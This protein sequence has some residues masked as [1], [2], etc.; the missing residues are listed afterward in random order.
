[1]RKE[2]SE[3]S[4]IGLTPL[5]TVLFVAEVR[6]TRVRFE[7][8]TGKDLPFDGSHILRD[9]QRA[10]FP[11]LKKPFSEGTRAGD[12]HGTRIWER[13]ERGRLL[14][15]VF[16]PTEGGIVRVAYSWSGLGSGTGVVP[17]VVLEDEGRDYRLVIETVP[18]G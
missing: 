10:F 7:N 5:N 17:R 4:L 1:M 12:I 18:E 11:W 15:R 9:V 3:L 13:E 2:G 6:G 14:E 16:T 8:R